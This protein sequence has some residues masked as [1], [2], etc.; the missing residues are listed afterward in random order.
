M[1][2]F[3]KRA[4][5]AIADNGY[6]HIFLGVVVAF[7]GGWEVADT[8]VEDIKSGHIQSGHGVFLIGIWHILKAVGELVESTDYL[9][10]GLDRPS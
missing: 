10:E 9:S 5:K 6:A 7:S 3:M 4:I 2:N 1:E 8:L